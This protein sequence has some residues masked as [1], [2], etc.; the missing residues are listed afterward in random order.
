MTNYHIYAAVGGTKQR[1]NKSPVNDNGRRIIS[2]KDLSK[3]F[4]FGSWSV[5]V[6]FYYLIQMV[7]TQLNRV[8][9]SFKD[10]IHCLLRIVIPKVYSRTLHILHIN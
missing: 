1:R 8:F 2:Y 10:Y 6:T 5:V 3:D 9:K 7:H 4:T